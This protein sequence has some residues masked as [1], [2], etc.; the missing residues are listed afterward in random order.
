MRGQ[1]LHPIWECAQVLLGTSVSSA[2]LQKEP[3]SPPDCSRRNTSRPPPTHTHRHPRLLGHSGAP[4]PSMLSS[5]LPLRKSS[6]RAPGGAQLAGEFDPLAS[7]PREGQVGAAGNLKSH[8]NGKE[9]SLRKAHGHSLG[10]RG[11][12][13][14]GIC[15]PHTQGWTLWVTRMETQLAQA[16]SQDTGSWCGTSG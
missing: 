2:L 6:G 9:I 10:L 1:R 16:M 15:C 11:P 4:V 12:G 8:S 5:Q 14:K 3:L 7:A 13:R